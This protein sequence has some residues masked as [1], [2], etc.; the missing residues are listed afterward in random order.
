V[1]CT[2]TLKEAT[3]AET[4]DFKCTNPLSPSLGFC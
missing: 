3:A 1:L 2:T 4:I